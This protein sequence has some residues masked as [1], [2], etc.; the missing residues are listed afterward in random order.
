M[1]WARTKGDEEDQEFTL[2]EDDFKRRRAHPNF[3]AHL[4]AERELKK[5]SKRGHFQL[6]VIGSGIQYHG[7]DSFFHRYLK[8]KDINQ[9]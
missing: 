7:G 1:T 8:V 9:A 6:Y 3:K 5:A 4:N 2:V